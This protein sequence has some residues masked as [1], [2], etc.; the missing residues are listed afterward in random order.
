MSE[1]KE[2]ANPQKKKASMLG[3]L[4]KFVLCLFVLALVICGAGAGWVYNWLEQPLVLTQ[5]PAQVEIPSGTSS[6]EVVNRIVAAG[7]QVNPQLLYYYFRY[8]GQ[9]RDIKAGTYEVTSQDT[10]RSV[11]RKLV[12][13]D[14]AMQTLVIPEGWTFK[15]IRAR[16]DASPD[17]I[18]ETKGMTDAQ[19]METLGKPGM[20]PEGLFFPDTYSFHPGSSDLK[21][22][23]RSMQQMDKTLEQVWQDKEADLP[24]KNTYEVLIMAS[25]I[26]KETGQASDRF[27]VAGVFVNRLRQGMLLQTDPTVIY[28]MGDSYQ[29]RIRRKDLDTDTP[30]NT[31]TR[32]GLTPTPIAMPGRDSLLAAVHPAKTK[33][34]YF[35]SRGDGSSHFSDTLQDHNR[36][37]DRYIRGKQVTVKPSSTVIE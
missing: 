20:H 4:F 27:M 5:T 35:V 28:G 37:V 6:K 30:Y 19:I 32:A 24:Y 18:H 33:A 21:L 23:Q 2:N 8:S 10:P 7:V 16:L 13:G 29:G 11:L 17:L 26:E 15:Q 25:I 1:V 12:N 34:L 3:R 9:S 22:L 14:V 36:A 31:Y